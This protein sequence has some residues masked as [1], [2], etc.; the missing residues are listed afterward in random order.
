MP[1]IVVVTAP[2]VT[3]RGVRDRHRRS[4]VC[5][6]PP[7]GRWAARSLEMVSTNHHVASIT[8]SLAGSGT[9]PTSTAA[10][11]TLRDTIIPATSATFAGT[12]VYVA[13]HD[14]RPRV[15]FNQTMKDHSFRGR[16]RLGLAFLLLLVAFRSLVIPLPRSC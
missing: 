16:P 7:S 15:D 8:V 14:R 13:G 12:H 1:A 5:A 6:A 9:D 11:S 3:A 4:I 2:D 10:L